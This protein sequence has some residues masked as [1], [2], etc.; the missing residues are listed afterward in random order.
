MYMASKGMPAVPFFLTLAI[1][2]EILCGVAILIGFRARVAAG[3]LFLY[4]IPVTLIFH[5]FWSVPG[6]EKQMQ[7]VN[8]L[9][10]ISILGGLLHVVVY[11]A[12]R[13][14]VDQSRLNE[15]NQEEK[16]AQVVE[17]QFRRAG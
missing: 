12:G 1:L 10:N 16:L 3:L 8:F 5:N 14:S 17:Q 15:E 11:G 9:K 4:L 13:H 7:F 2:F 6:V